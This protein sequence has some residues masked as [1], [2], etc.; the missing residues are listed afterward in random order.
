MSSGA[1]ERGAHVGSIGA[2]GKRS[3]RLKLGKRHAQSS[4]TSTVAK[5]PITIAGSSP[6]HAAMSP[7][8]NIAT[9]TIG[10]P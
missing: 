9:V 2:F 8:S 7:D 6:S 3:I 10:I 4:V 1:A 5:P